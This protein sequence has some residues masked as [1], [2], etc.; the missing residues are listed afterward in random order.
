MNNQ[1]PRLISEEA[2][3][4]PAL[5]LGPFVDVKDKQMLIGKVPHQNT[6]AVIRNGD[7]IELIQTNPDENHPAIVVHSDYVQTLIELLV[8]AVEVPSDLPVPCQSDCDT[9]RQ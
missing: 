1:A 2:V 6:I 5:A 9:S 4:P 3:S 8:A 7:Y